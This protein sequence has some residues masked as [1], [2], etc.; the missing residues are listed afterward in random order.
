MS[1]ASGLS[2]TEVR[3]VVDLMFMERD[4]FHEINLNLVGGG[5]AAQ[6]IVAGTIHRL[7]NR[8]NRR[9]VVAGGGEVRSEK[10]IVHVEFADSGPIRPSRPFRADA[11]VRR[12]PQ[13]GGTPA[14]P[15]PVLPI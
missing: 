15:P 12:D 13:Y 4:T 7:R 1:D 3:D 6:Q 2:G 10:S 14:R 9:D 11:L 5:D 8:K